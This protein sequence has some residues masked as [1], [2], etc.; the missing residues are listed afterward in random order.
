MPKATAYPE[1]DRLDEL[2]DEI[3]DHLIKMDAWFEENLS[4]EELVAHYRS[5]YHCAVINWNICLREIVDLR[6]RVRQWEKK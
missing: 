2:L 6:A 5:H 3:E 1:G 4:T